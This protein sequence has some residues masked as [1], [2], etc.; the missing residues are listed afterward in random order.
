MKKLAYL[1]ILAPLIGG[2]WII[3]DR[4][5]FNRDAWLADFEQLKT[6]TEQSYANLKWSRD[7]KQIDLVTL[8]TK[9]I[10]ELN[11]AASNSAARKALA[12]F[13]NGFNDGHFHIESGPPRP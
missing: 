7:A 11:T 5:T 13:I 10:Q 9:T 3:Q 6:A 12:G 4:A 1:L 2:G 8:N